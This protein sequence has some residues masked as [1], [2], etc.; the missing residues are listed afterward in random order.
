[1]IATVSQMQNAEER[2]F[3]TGVEAEPLMDRAGLGIAEA[4]VERL[5]GSTPG[6]LRAF[7]GPGHNGGDA[8]VAAR[9]LA[10]RGWE[11]E[12][13][14]V[15][16]ERFRPLTEKKL[17]E[18][19]GPRATASRE[20]MVLLDGLLGIGARGPLHGDIAEAAAEMNALRVEKFAHTVAIDLPSGLDGDSGEPCAGA[21]VADLTLVIAR[22][23]AGL[24]ADAAIDHVGRLGLVP[25]DEI[26]LADGDAGA[27]LL[28]P[29]QLAK[30]LPRRPF[31]THKGQ[32]GRV[33]IGAGSRGLTG[34]AVLSSA[35]AVRGG[36]GLVTLFVPDELYPVLAATTISEV[37]VRPWRNVGEVAT[38]NFDVL[39]IGPGLGT[40]GAEEML[41]LVE[42]DPR[43]CVVDADAL[44][45]I[46]EQGVDLLARCPGP[47]LLTP[48]PGEMERLFPRQGRSRRE[49]AEAFAQRFPNCTLLLKGARTIIKE[50]GQPAAFNPTGHPGMATG[51]LG[52]VLTG[53]SAALIGQGQSTY[54][55][56]CGAS[57][58]TGRAAELALSQQSEESFAA[59]DAIAQ[60]GGAFR[61]LRLS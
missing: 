16:R 12:L 14:L 11:V 28:E 17:A 38:A 2:L 50:E 53:L 52:D 32:T 20:P 15:G 58:L 43:P 10:A 5:A 7:V 36:A 60:L 44:N 56:G 13:R 23:K 48:H 1:M 21:V 39:A 61:S 54:E 27:E 6:A 4:I 37:M 18:L 3:A 42:E 25:L 31:D 47:R 19:G 57:W 24:V 33:A 45:Q 9:H 41:S 22:A 29:R 40:A 26:E 35:A 46:A 49:W 30:L 34:A 8:L 51:G 59:S 55:A